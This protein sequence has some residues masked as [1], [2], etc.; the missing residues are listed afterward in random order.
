MLDTRLY[1]LMV[2]MAVVT[3]VMT[4]PVL[5]LVY[6]DRMI[7]ADIAEAQQSLTSAG[8]YSVLAILNDTDEPAL[9]AAFG[10]E[11]AGPDGDLLIA[12]FLPRTDQPKQH[13][14]LSGDLMRMAATLEELNSLALTCKHTTAS[15]VAQL[16]DDVAGDVT[17][18]ILRARVN[19]AVAGP[20]MTGDAEKARSLCGDASCDLVT[21]LP[22]ATPQDGGIVA[23]FGGGPDDGAVLEVATRLWLTSRSVS[24][25]AG[26]GRG[27]SPPGASPAAASP[28][29]AGVSAPPLGL[30]PEASAH[31][32]VHRLSE[33]LQSLDIAEV[34]ME[35]TLSAAPLAV[36]AWPPSGRPVPL[37]PITTGPIAVVYSSEDPE[38]VGIDQRL[39]RLDQARRP[40][41]P[42]PR[43]ETAGQGL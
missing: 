23:L 2:I 9:L 29:G 10:A 34:T 26:A 32:R 43:S 6:P 20:S 24:A 8:R 28:D 7:E 35:E 18:L 11:L 38:R 15:P 21:L 25:G 30:V 27:A 42:A 4:S 14:G 5:R 37:S 1:T 12:R 3:T 22:G 39:I 36:R 19:A 31:G 41:P 13:A 16:S 40:R 33:R 17:A